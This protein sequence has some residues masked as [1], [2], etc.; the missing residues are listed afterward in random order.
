M[1]V[2]PIDRDG[3]M[4]FAFDNYKVVH[5]PPHNAFSL[6]GIV[7]VLVLQVVTHKSAAYIT[8]K[9]LLDKL[10]GGCT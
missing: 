9:G 5:Y 10:P 6:V 7:H 8:M 2:Y 4:I 3:K 1:H